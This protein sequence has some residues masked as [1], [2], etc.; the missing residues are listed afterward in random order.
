MKIPFFEIV[1]ANKTNI[2]PWKSKGGHRIFSIMFFSDYFRTP[3][4]EKKMMVGRSNFF[5]KTCRPMCA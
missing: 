2:N 5:N 4:S 1:T 3:F